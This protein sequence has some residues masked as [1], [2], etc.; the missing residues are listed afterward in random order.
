MLL[1]PQTQYLE[2][3]RGWRDLVDVALVFLL[4]YGLLRLIRGTRAAP[5]A[6]GIGGLAL[7]YWAAARYDLA[8]LEFILRPA[9]LYVG[10]AIIVL[11][12]TKIPKPLI[13]FANRSRIPFLLPHPGQSAEG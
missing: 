10:V 11:F 1:Q 8:T 13:P 12:R 4:V 3:L 6:A 5:M 2:S 9:P 7:L